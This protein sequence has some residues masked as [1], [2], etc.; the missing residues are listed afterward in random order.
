MNI[1]EADMLASLEANKGWIGAIHCADSNRLAP[2]MGHVDFPGV[3]NQAKDYPN[4]LY[5]GVE[6]LPL[7]DS[8]SSARTA[9]A[10]IKRAAGIY[11]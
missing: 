8:L 1:E 6:V 11:I 4:L 9:I 2:G 5:F 10:T 7:P 3:L